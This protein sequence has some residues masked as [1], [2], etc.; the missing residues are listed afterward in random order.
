MS[1]LKQRSNTTTTPTIYLASPASLVLFEIQQIQSNCTMCTIFSTPEA[2]HEFYTQATSRT[3]TRQRQ[4]DAANLMHQAGI[5][6]ETG[7]TCQPQFMISRAL[8]ECN[9][10]ARK[11]SLPITSIQ[12]SSYAA[13]AQVRDQRAAA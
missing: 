6:E 9:C 7:T 8:D 2:S 3:D 13:T 11:D 1:S 10:W 5:P 4:S 12:H